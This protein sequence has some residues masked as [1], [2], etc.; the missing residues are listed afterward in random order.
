MRHRRL[1]VVVLLV[2]AAGLTAAA[3]PTVNIAGK[4]V[5]QVETGQ[6]SGSPTV[7]FTQDGER[8]TGHYSGQLGEADFTGTVKGAAVHFSFSTNA[9]GMDVDVVYDGEVDGTSMK[10]TVA[11]AGGQVA[12]TFIGK[13]Q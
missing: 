13:K 12:G 4:W 9:Q 10:G 5:F 11:I 7:S 1:R 3:A 6:G 8:L 2:I